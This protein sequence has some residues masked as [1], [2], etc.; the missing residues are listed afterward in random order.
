MSAKLLDAQDIRQAFAD[1]EK[2]ARTEG[3]SI[4]AINMKTD[5]FDTATI[6]RMTGLSSEEIEKL[7]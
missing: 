2:K 3:V 1:A 7:S 6:S 5:G 4:V